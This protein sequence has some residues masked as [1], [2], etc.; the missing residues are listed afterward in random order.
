M[1]RRINID[2]TSKRITRRRGMVDSCKGSRV[3]RGRERMFLKS[4]LKRGRLRLYWEI[5]ETIDHKG[6]LVVK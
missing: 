3:S 6:E 2:T 1:I 4:E 5:L